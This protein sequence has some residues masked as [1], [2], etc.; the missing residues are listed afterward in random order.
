[1]TVKDELSPALHFVFNLK[2]ELADPGGY[3][4]LV[5]SCVPFI[6]TIVTEVS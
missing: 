5:S 6:S 1:M 3:F 2:P 4:K